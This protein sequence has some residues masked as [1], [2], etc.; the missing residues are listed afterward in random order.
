MTAVFFINL[1]PNMKETADLW[2]RVAAAEPGLAKR[3]AADSYSCAEQLQLQ[4]S[5]TV[6]IAGVHFA[7]PM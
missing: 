7:L 4:S 1:K 2:E 3:F 6:D 5:E